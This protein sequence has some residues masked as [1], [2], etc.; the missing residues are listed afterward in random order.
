MRATIKIDGETRFEFEVSPEV[1]EAFVYA[2]SV[3]VLFGDAFVG[4]ATGC[5]CPGCRATVELVDGSEGKEDAE[6]W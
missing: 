6:E 2:E 1:L 4:I 3:E 5:V